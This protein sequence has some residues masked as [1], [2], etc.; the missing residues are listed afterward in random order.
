MPQFNERIEF[1][2][3]GDAILVGD[4]NPQAEGGIAASLVVAGET[5]GEIIIH[6]NSGKL[7]SGTFV[8]NTKSTINH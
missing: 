5:P 3:E 1:T 2:I 6:A 8:I 4:S 7:I